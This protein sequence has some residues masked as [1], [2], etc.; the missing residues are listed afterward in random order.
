MRLA[1]LLAL[2]LGLTPVG[3]FAAAPPPAKPAV[4]A[5]AAALDRLYARLARTPYADEAVGILTEIDQM[6]TQSGSDTADLLLARAQKARAAADLSLALQ[7]FDAVVDLYPEWSEAWSERAAARYQSGDVGG[8]MGDLAQTLKREPRDVGA[9]AGLG[10][11]LLD[12]GNPEA[13]LKVYDRALK[14]APAYE[15]LQEARARAQNMVWSRS[16]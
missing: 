13:A 2:A 1:F 12:S 8:A 16:P 15:P 10:A 7:L 6:R 11:I 9:L 14:L 4:S 5:D 3:A